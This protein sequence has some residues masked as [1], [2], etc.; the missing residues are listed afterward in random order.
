[1]RLCTIPAHVPFLDTLAK[2]W[3]EQNTDDLARGLILLPTRRAARALS[4]S[5]LS[6]SG[7][8][9]LLLPRITAF[10]AV[11]E[12]PLALAGA[13]D[14][15]PSVEP[16][17]RLAALAALILRVP[18]RAGGVRTTEGAWMLAGELAALMDEAERAEIDLR[19]ALDHAAA[20]EYAEHWGVTLRF[21]EIVTG[22]WPRWLAEEGLM[23]PAARQVALLRAQA[24]AWWDAPPDDPVWVAGT[25]GAIPVV[26]EL[27]RVVAGLPQGLVVLPD[28]DTTLPDDAWEALDDAHPQAALARLLASMG[29][30]RGD[31]EIWHGPSTVA[32]GRAATLATALLPAASLSAWRQ[33]PTLDTEGLRRLSPADQQEEAA[34]IALIL[35][36]ALETP[37]NRAALVTSD[38]AL[39]G[40]VSAELSRWGVVADDSAGE[41]LADTPPAVFL[42]L[43]AEAVAARLAPVKLLAALKHPFAAAGL[44]PAACRAAA[45]KLEVATLR[46]P[47]PEAGFVGIRRRLDAKQRVDPAAIDLL[48]RLEERLAP[49]F[50]IAS[51][52]EVAPAAALEALIAAAE[53]LAATNEAPGAARLWAHEEGE[54]LAVHLA[55]ARDAF[56]LLPDQ[57]PGALPGLLEA[58]FADSAVRTRRALRGREATA[59]HPRVMIWGLLEARMQAVDVIVLGGLAEGVWPPATEPGPWMS[60]PMRSRAGLPSPEEAIGLAAH[61]FVMAACAAP[62]AVLSCPRRRDGAPSVPARWLVRLD[63][64]LAGQGRS[65]DLH[66]ATR[67]AR[68]LDQPAGPPRP[69]RP[70]APRPPVDLRPR[71]LS[72]TQ[73]ETWLSDPYAIHARHVL[74]LRPLDPLEQETDASDYGALVH[75]GLEIFLGDAGAAWPPNAAQRLREAMDKALRQSGVRPALFEWWAP[76]L[77]RIADW[78]AEEETKRRAALPPVAIHAEVRGEWALDVPRGFILHGRADRIERR[79]DGSLAILDYKTGAPPTQK[80]VDSGFAPQ[81]PLEAAM[82]AAGGFGEGLRGEAA[83]LTYW[84]LTGGFEPGQVRSLCKGDLARIRDT[85]ATA[86]EKLK[87]LIERF[88][89]P[90]MPYLARPHPARAPRFSDSAQLA[91]VAEWDLSGNEP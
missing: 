51:A 27:L 25:T 83:E 50:R 59:E 33:S 82:V 52:T 17:R 88:D 22:A 3:L 54:A 89:D 5:F 14:L 2:A 78:I 80:Q 70:P 79:P 29:A 18:E 8:K 32:P 85:V 19:T 68:L 1:M 43:L 24:A 90:A 55:T 53:A 39:A 40:R 46:G 38:R 81:L 12:T 35:R 57:P 15:P 7:G 31:V 47:R 20:A 21:L 36:D 84:R 37:G 60:R 75:R 28:L 67:W 77:A 65:F 74:R 91:R 48:A 9:P 45:R 42:R 86:A 30:T 87:E 23:N 44:A 6:V 41:K 26:A 11:D 73:I 71:K 13:L 66:P 56:T 4:A 49:L 58:L 64:L 63:A 61:D 72:V 10:G 16:M 76:R 69:V 62:F 34:A